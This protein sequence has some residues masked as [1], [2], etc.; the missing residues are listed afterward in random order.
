MTL[1]TPNQRHAAAA[2]AIKDLL[3]RPRN[4]FSPNQS[5]RLV[6][7]GLVAYYPIHVETG[8][9]VK[10]YISEILQEHQ[11]FLG[12]GNDQFAIVVCWG[13]KIRIEVKPLERLRHLEDSHWRAD[14]WRELGD[15]AETYNPATHVNI[16]YISGDGLDCTKLQAIVE[17][18]REWEF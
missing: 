16:G 10:E 12:K 14:L 17:A 15:R 4:P 7:N 13:R 2:I 9:V 6:S 8:L 11:S 3:Y 5:R 1:K 18:C